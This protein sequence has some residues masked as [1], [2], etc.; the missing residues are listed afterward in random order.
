M[1]IFH[2]FQTSTY[3]TLPLVAPVWKDAVGL[4][5]GYDYLMHAVLSVSAS[6]LA[7]LSK[8]T[9]YKIQSQKHLS[10]ALRLFRESLGKGAID[11]D[12]DA[13]L[14][15]S[16]LIY[17]QAW[18]SPDSLAT[19]N[20]TKE[21]NEGLLYRASDDQL[22][23]LASGMRHLFSSDKWSPLFKIS[24]F[25]RTIV[26]RPIKA[27]ERVTLSLGR[28]PFELEC[29]LAGFYNQPDKISD[30]H[31]RQLPD[32]LI[33]AKT[34]PREST[35]SDIQPTPID[36]PIC[37]YDAYMNVAARLSILLSLLPGTGEDSTT[38][39][40]QN[41]SSSALDIQPELLYDVSRVVY[42]FSL[43]LHPHFLSMLHD[44][45]SRALLL[46]YYFYRMVQ[47]L[48]PK[49]DCWWA[50]DRAEVMQQRLARNLWG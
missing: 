27:I 11:D 17:Y 4:A 35:Y 31:A 19:E 39:M 18:S 16:A 36:F 34:Q 25:S 33:S 26:H 9:H 7:F 30:C 41:T 46:L 3:R 15:T 6:H 38:P 44:N 42:T 23:G 37:A 8:N 5:F 22:L 29:L 20:P 14:A 32:Q 1:Y 49:Q 45:D 48:L 50:S 28:N 40:G 24:L 10:Y 2:H 47:D 13:I 12:S 43:M 21:S